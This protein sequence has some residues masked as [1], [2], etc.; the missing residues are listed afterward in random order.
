MTQDSPSMQDTFD[1][2]HSSARVLVIEDEPTILMNIRDTLELEGFE[3]LGAENGRTGITMAR[4]HIPD[5][6]VCDIM[7]PHLDGY[8]VLLALREDPATASIPFVFLTAKA[9]HTDIRQG[10]VLGA[11]DYLTKPFSP[12]ELINAVQTRLARQANLKQEYETKME[13]L[14]E[15]IIHMLPHELRTPLHV[16]LGYSEL[17]ALGGESMDSSRVVAMAQAISRAGQRLSRLVENFLVYAQ[18]ELVFK[19]EDRVLA[20]RQLRIAQPRAL[21][22]FTAR[23]WAQALHR[24][25]DLAVVVHEVP[26]VKIMQDSLKKIVEELVAYCSARSATR[27]PA[28]TLLMISSLLSLGIR[29]LI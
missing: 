2:D 27:S 21:I 20:I 18:T 1:G 3:T 11:D 19:S 10:M 24:E 13:A 29:R 22:E 4:E 9:S 14:R 6:I 28:C 12:P 5:L 26:F 7:M 16:I 15:G 25:L 17:L 8:G 23:Q